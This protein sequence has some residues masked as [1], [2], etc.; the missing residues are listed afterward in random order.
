MKLI[1][2][3]VLFTMVLILSVLF[4]SHGQDKVEIGE[5]KNGKLVITGLDALKA[6]LLNSLGN[7]GTLGND[8]KVRAAPEGNRFF[9]H[10]AVKDNKDNVACIGILLV[11]IKDKVFIVENPPQTMSA[12]GGTG[13]SFE[14]TC[15]GVD[16]N[17][18]VPNIKW[19]SGTWLPVVYCECKDGGG[20]ICNMTSRLIVQV[21]L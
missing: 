2:K 13:G 1:M 18:C 20:G 21:N 16:C 3:K 4:V 17:S 12:G 19:V 14:I 8:Y 6:F 11:K 10:F 15:I 9:V 5:V 7:T